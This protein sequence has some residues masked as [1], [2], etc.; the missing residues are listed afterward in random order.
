M[1]KQHLL[2]VAVVCACT[3][4]LATT[5]LAQT[6]SPSGAGTGSTGGTKSDT[7]PAN[8]TTAAATGASTNTGTASTGDSTGTGS[9]MAKKGQDTMEDRV[10]H[11]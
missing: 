11:N 2:A 6:A 3:A 8:P 9:S 1:K 5:A 7:M 4:G 10:P